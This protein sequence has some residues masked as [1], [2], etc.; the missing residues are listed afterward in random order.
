MTGLVAEQLL[1]T[2]GS[3][4]TYNGSVGSLNCV[5]VFSQSCY[6]H[7]TIFKMLESISKSIDH[8]M[9]IYIVIIIHSSSSNISINILCKKKT[10]L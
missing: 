5:H 3:K 2:L 8:C 1:I 9:Y 7:K 6:T 10:I 4:Q